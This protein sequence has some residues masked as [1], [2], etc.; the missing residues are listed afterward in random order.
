MAWFS[1]RYPASGSIPIIIHPH[2]FLGQGASL[3]AG[4]RVI[5]E[6]CLDKL[7]SNLKNFAKQLVDP[8][9]SGNISEIS[10]RLSQ[11]ELNFEAFVNAFTIKVN[12]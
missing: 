9:V 7:R 12:N 5:N 10:A 2:N 8:N 4:M 1:G 3:V 11:F 6:K